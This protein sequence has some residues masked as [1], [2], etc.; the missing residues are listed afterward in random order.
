MTRQAFMARLREAPAGRAVIDQ[1][2]GIIMR[3]SGC[4]A[5]AAFDELR[6]ISQHHQVKVVELARLLID[7]HRR[8]HAS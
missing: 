5:E 8:D 1:A 4:S 7:E 6:R 2:K 3:T